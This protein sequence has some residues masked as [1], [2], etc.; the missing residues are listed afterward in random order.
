MVKI[1]RPSYFRRISIHQTLP[2]GTALPINSFEELDPPIVQYLKSE[3]NNFL[4]VVPFKLTSPPP[5]ANVIDKNCCIEWLDNQEPNSVAYIEFGTVATPPPNELRAM[6][7]TLEE[8][9]I[10]FLWS[11]KEKFMSHFP[12]GFLENARMFG[13]IVPWA[14]QVQV[15]EHKSFGVFI[16]HSGWNSVLESI[17]SGVPLI[18]MPLFGDHHLNSS[19]VEKVWK[20]G[21]K[22]EGGFFTKSGTIVALDFVLSKIKEELKK[23]IGMYKEL[24]HKAVGPNGSSTQNFKKLVEIITSC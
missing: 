10:P 8:R 20:I 22:I 5:L 4:N 1:Y 3:F 9:K 2:K 21:V 6:A 11:I 12:N 24:V 16:N 13:K 23:Q 18:C 7:E 14:P 17:A 19:M 15:L